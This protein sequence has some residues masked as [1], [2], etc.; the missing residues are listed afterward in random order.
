VHRAIRHRLRG[1]T[2]ENYAY[3]VDSLQGLG[4]KCSSMERRADEATR[5]VAYSLKCRYMQ[6]KVGGEYTGTIT[7]ATSFGLFVELDDIFVEGLVHVT[8]LNN[9]Y[10]KHDPV[11]HCLRGEASGVVYRLS[12]KITVQVARVNLETRKIDFVLPNSEA[13][14][15]PKKSRKPR[16]R[17]KK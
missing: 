16:K 9:D 3:T 6:N 2:A 7:A 5:D 13:N 10:Y 11:H 14:T 1:N 12:D 4:E 17:N 15:K 8:A